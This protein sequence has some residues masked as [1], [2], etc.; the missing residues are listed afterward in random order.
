[1]PQAKSRCSSSAKEQCIGGVKR[2]AQQDVASYWALQK[3]TIIGLQHPTHSLYGLLHVGAG[4]G[5]VDAAE[6]LAVGAKG[7]TAVEANFCFV[8]QLAIEFLV[9]EAIRAKVEPG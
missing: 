9:I 2:K 4:T 8:D 7:A 3:N 5:Q 1:M 6:T